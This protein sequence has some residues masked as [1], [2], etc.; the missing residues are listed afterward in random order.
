[1]SSVRLNTRNAKGGISKIT[2]EANET[3]DDADDLYEWLQDDDNILDCTVLF[4]KKYDETATQFKLLRSDFCII[5]ATNKRKLL[6]ERGLRSLCVDKI[7]W[8]RSDELSITVLFVVDN[9]GVEHT[10]AFMFSDR[11]DAYIYEVFFTKLK[12]YLEDA[13]PEILLTPVSPGIPIAFKNATKIEITKSVFSPWQL[14][15]AWRKHLKVIKKAG[16]RRE[17]YKTLR[18]LQMES[19][20]S[21]FEELYSKFLSEIKNSSVRMNLYEFKS[22]HGYGKEHVVR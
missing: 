12:R 10:V 17:I 16:K 5:V 7:P 14:D 9:Y 21:E 15:E 19:D 2:A 13:Q 8:Y 18:G 22:M 6:R 3:Q 4:S 11:N 1:M 20:Q